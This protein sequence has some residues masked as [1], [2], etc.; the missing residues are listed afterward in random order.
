MQVVQ[1]NDQPAIDLNKSQLSQGSTTRK[2]PIR[3]FAGKGVY[4]INTQLIAE[5]SIPKPRKPKIAGQPYNMEY[6][7]KLF[8]NLQ[9][10]V[11]ENEAL[12]ASDTSRMATL[13]NAGYFDLLGLTPKNQI[14]YVN[15]ILRP[16]VIA[17]IKRLLL[18]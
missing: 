13:K 16:E 18:T 6:T 12:F 14:T 7:G 17:N 8:D 10:L 2:R 15:D 9:L 1:E 11:K 4:S 5:N 3:F